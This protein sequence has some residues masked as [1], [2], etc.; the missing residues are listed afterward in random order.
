M[1]IREYLSTLYNVNSEK[2][3]DVK[4]MSYWLE[5]YN[6]KR[7]LIALE[8]GEDKYSKIIYASTIDQTVLMTEKEF[9]KYNYS[10][11]TDDYSFEFSGTYLPKHLS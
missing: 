1:T 4:T 11:D 2:L 5:K 6:E 3:E 10:Q 9:F 7:N 8:N